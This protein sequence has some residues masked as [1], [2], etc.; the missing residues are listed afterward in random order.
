M[1]ADGKS[2]VTQV[3]PA[4][5]LPQSVKLMR[6][7]FSNVVIKR[8]YTLH[9]TRES[10]LKGSAY[11]GF[12]TRLLNKLDRARREGA[13]VMTTPEALKSLQ[14]K[15]VD[16][17]QGIESLNPLYYQPLDRLDKDKQADARKR[18]AESKSNAV[19]ADILRTIMQ[20]WGDAGGN[21]GILLMD[22][23]DVLL[24]PLRSELNF[25]INNKHPLDHSP[26]RWDFPIF[27][28]V[29]RPCTQ[30]ISSQTPCHPL[31]QTNCSPPP[32]ANCSGGLLLRPA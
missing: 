15:Y 19:S 2:L 1:L 13:I 11:L 6:A 17:L 20:L 8:V 28:M 10:P 32:P 16:L 25:P 31:T 12:V 4:N 18:I 14:L 23:V 30:Q 21:G 7:R 29:T 27:L 3:Q 22:E 5:L 9:F 26:Y 24:H